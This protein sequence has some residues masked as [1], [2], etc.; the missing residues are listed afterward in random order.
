MTERLPNDAYWVERGRIMAGPYPGAQYEVE[1][2]RKVGD[3]LDAGV[4][5]FIDLTEDGEL[6]PYADTALEV[7]AARGIEIAHHRFPVRDVSIPTEE[8]M[9]HALATTRAAAAAGAIPY[10]HC[11]GGVGRT[12]TLVGCM[13]I[14]DGVPADEVIGHIREL[15]AGTERAR[16]CSPQTAEQ[17]DFVFAWQP[18]G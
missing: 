14:E 5:T 17:E 15:R 12:G 9:R 13:L 16:R 6:S 3:L 11:W 18:A 10:V 4:R 1:V 8:V 7:A 2:P